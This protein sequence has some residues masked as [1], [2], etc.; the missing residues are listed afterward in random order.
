MFAFLL[1]FCVSIIGFPLAVDYNIMTSNDDTTR[2]P[3]A[4]LLIVLW[5]LGTQNASGAEF[6]GYVALATDYVKRGVTQSNGDPAFQIGTD[7]GFDNGLFMGLWGSTADI[8]NGPT[9]QR[10]IELNYYAGYALDL[11]DSWQLTLTAVVY[12]YPGQTGNF[13][14]DYEEYSLGTGFNDR[15]W[16]DIAYS[17]DLYNSGNSTTNIELYTEWPIGRIWA[18]GGGAGHYD[19]SELSG[20]SYSYWQ[21]GLTAALSWADIDL[22]VHGTDDWVPIVSTRDRAKSRLVLKI[23]I[24]F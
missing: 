5:L 6:G 22:R 3:A 10:D 8:S 13:N 1:I 21:V 9:S 24:P 12:D 20:R 15:L 17:P 2:R 11:S 7:V 23:Q 4:I 16:L 14:Y 19:T 18:I